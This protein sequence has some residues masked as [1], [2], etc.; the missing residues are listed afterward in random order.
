MSPIHLPRVKCYLRFEKHAEDV[1]DTF[2]D[3]A[4]EHP[5]SHSLHHMP[6]MRMV[7]SCRLFYVRRAIMRIMGY[8][9]DEPKDACSS[10]QLGGRLSH[11]CCTHAVSFARCLQACLGHSITQAMCS[12]RTCATQRRNTTRSSAETQTFALPEFAE[13]LDRVVWAD[14]H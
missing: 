2:A 11:T 7:S 12:R 14:K 9:T 10:V 8:R 13:R 6:Y 5:S 1:V 4:V 3:G